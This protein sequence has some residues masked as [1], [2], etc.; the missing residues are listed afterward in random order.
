MTTVTSHSA[1]KI[2]AGAKSTL[3]PHAP[4]T[5][6]STSAMIMTS[7]VSGTSSP[8]AAATADLAMARD[9]TSHARM[10]YRLDLD[11]ATAQR[12]SFAPAA[13]LRH[14][15]SASLRLRGYAGAGVRGGTCLRG[16]DGQHRVPGGSGSPVC[17]DLTAQRKGRRGGFVGPRAARDHTWQKLRRCP[18]YSCM[19]LRSS[20]R[21]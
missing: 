16:G 4:K 8:A 20:W 21:P 13:A 19:V 12:G 5:V 3:D 1:D 2:E 10:F 14:D 9:C 7:T 6:T 11:L 18:C 17:G 15:R